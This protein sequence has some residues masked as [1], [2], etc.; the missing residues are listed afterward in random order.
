MSEND[1]DQITEAEA[2]ELLGVTP[3]TLAQRRHRARKHR[4]P[5]LSPPW[6]RRG[7]RSIRYRRSEVLSWQAA[8]NE[9]VPEDPAA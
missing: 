4:D 3:G 8:R 7:D 6:Y 5:K 9:L 1:D 2:A